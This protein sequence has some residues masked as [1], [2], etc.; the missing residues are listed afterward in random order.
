MNHRREPDSGS[1]GGSGGEREH[2]GSSHDVGQGSAEARQ[3]GDRAFRPPPSGPQWPGREV[4]DAERS[5]V[6][7]TDTQARTPLGVGTSTSRRAEKIAHREDEVGSRPHG[8][9]GRS[10]RPHG[11]SA[12]EHDTGVAPQAPIHED[13]P[14]IPTGDQAG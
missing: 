2:H 4:S 10:G 8:L 9:R 13:S 12:P 3:A 7:A 1:G 5:G 14:H 11:K 6:P